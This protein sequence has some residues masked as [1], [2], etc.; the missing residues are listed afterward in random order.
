M[1]VP[2]FVCDLCGFNLRGDDANSI[3]FMHALRVTGDKKLIYIKD[4][5][6]AMGADKHI[7]S[8]CVKFFP[9]GLEG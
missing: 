9:V 4:A 8:E 5:K 3:R 2:V 7:C 6:E 1:K